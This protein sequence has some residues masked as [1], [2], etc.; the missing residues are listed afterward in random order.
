MLRPLQKILMPIFM[1]F[2]TLFAL[3]YV[4]AISFASIR[5]S[6]GIHG[7][8]SLFSNLS[9]FVIYLIPANEALKVIFNSFLSR[10]FAKKQ[11]SFS[12]LAYA[13]V[14]VLITF[15]VT[16]YVGIGPVT[17]LTMLSITALASLFLGM[18]G[19]MI[20][21]FIP[22]LLEKYLQ[23]SRINAVK[24][25]LRDRCN[26]VLGERQDK[27]YDN[28]TKGV[29]L[30]RL[31]ADLYRKMGN[32]VYEQKD[33]RDILPK[34]GDQG[35]DLVIEDKGRHFIVQCKNYKGDI[36][37]EHVQQLCGAMQYYS[38]NFNIVGGVFIT[39]SSFKKS[40][41]D[42]AERSSIQLVDMDS[43]ASMLKTYKVS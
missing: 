16:K 6:S 23:N 39:T 34:W 8:N 35:L 12:N 24:N 41:I 31:A 10:Y 13:V 21:G 3:Q 43:F 11:I 20:I 19:F 25:A 5:T 4:A 17:A 7:A 28:V 37:N 29:A 9:L 27:K 36:T 14:G 30:E 40:A 26:G 32:K 18:R 22:G 33:L 38:A 2:I 15:L 42:L 1:F